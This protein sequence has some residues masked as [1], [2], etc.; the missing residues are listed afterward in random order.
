MRP[1]T[2]ITGGG[3]QGKRQQLPNRRPSETINF[4]WNDSAFTA[5]VSRC[6]T[7]RRVLEIFL[8]NHKTGGAIDLIAKDSAITCSIALQFGASFEVIRLGLLRDSRGV[9]ASPLGAAMDEISRLSE[10]EDRQ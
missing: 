1:P 2:D 10:P 4:T 9:P 7:T 3:A 8:G 5:T 6:P